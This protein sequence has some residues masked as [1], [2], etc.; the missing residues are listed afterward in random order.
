MKNLI[1]VLLKLIFLGLLTIA[2][3]IV[4]SLTSM[5]QCTINANANPTGICAGDSVELTSSGVC[6]DAF[7]L[8][9]FNDDFGTGWDVTDQA[10]IL[11][12]G[13]GCCAY[14]DADGTPFV[15][16]GPNSPAPRNIST[17]DFDLTSGGAC[18]VC[19]DMRYAPNDNS[20]CSG[21]CD[22]PDMSDE[23]VYL[24]YSTD[25]GTNWV[26]MDYWDPNGGNDATLTSWN[27]YCVDIPAAAI[28][29]AT[30]FRWAQKSS[31][32]GYNYADQWGLDN[33][34]IACPVLFHVSWNTGNPADTTF[35]PNHSFFPSSNTCYIV[36][37][38]DE[39]G[40]T[41]SDTVC[42]TVYQQPTS[43]FSVVSPLCHFEQSEIVYTGNAPSNADFHWDFGTATVAQ[44]TAGGPYLLA[45]ENIIQNTVFPVSLWVSLNGC[46]SDTSTRNIEVNQCYSELIVP[47]VF[48]PN[49]DGLNDYFSI[50]S[51][52]ITNFEL[53]IFNRWG[54]KV[55]EYSGL[56]TDGISDLWDGSI[57]HSQASDGVYFYVIEA[58]GED[59]QNYSLNGTVTVF[60]Q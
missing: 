3:L 21:E 50:Q 11:N 45:F 9:D 22:G 56:P 58:T 52:G 36:T 42:V 13:D 60:T 40:N 47:N 54:K 38:E 14:P 8:N 16:M 27:Q 49:G 44:G 59:L 57:G 51:E 39:L 30:R 25:G 41:A 5:A 19:F 12:G 48:T 26:E 7:M 18:Q 33:V 29:T 31:T 43:D 23:G 2:I 32:S 55:Y 24:E 34:S 15:W 46:S 35:N 6:G 4:I 53:I 1:P 28:T 17:I 20:T 10:I 37:I